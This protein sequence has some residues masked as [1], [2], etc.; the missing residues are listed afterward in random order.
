ME[1]IKLI[2]KNDNSNIA[3]YQVSTAKESKK[4]LSICKPFID[5]LAPHLKL[6]TE[7]HIDDAAVMKIVADI[8][9]IIN[10]RTKEI[11]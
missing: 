6:E 2:N 11:N 10:R 7:S 4:I 1:T 8:T 9:G 3:T 5:T